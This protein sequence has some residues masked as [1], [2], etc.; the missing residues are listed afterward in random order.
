MWEQDWALLGIAPTTEPGAIKKAYALKLKATRPDDDAQAYQALRA[1]YERV[2]QWLKWQ[3]LQQQQAH[4]PDAETPAAPLPPAAVHDAP[5]MPPP[6]QLVQP[7][8]LLDGLAR[9]WQRC[10]EAAL[11]HEWT[12]VQQQLAQQP[13]S[14]QTEFSAAFA[15][16]VVDAPAL[17]DPLLKALN[18]HFG[19]L[20]DFRTERLLGTPLTHALHEALDGRLRPPALPDPVRELGAPLQ[21]LAALHEAGHAGWRLQ[22]LFFLL[23]PT[24]ARCQDLLGA[25]WL[26]RL[27][28]TPPTQRWLAG[29]TRRHLGLRVGLATLLCWGAAIAI[30]AA[31]AQGRGLAR[32]ILSGLGSS[33]AWLALSCGLLIVGLLAGSLIGV[34]L[35]LG[36]R[37]GR[38]ARRLDAWRRHRSQPWLGLAGLLFAAWLCDLQAS[39]EAAGGMPSLLP[40]WAYGRAA[41][42]FGIAGLLLA[43]PLVPMHGRVVAGLAPLVGM[44]AMDALGAWLSRGSCLLLGLAWM[45]V[46][47]AVHEERLGLPAAVPLRWLLRPMLNSFALADRWTYALALAPLAVGMAWLGLG[48]GQVGALRLFVVWVLSILA[49]GWLQSR[50]DA[51]GLSQLRA[52]RADAG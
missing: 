2:Q 34:G 25:D 28:L 41:W 27:G 14:R 44:L 50:A 45:L 30:H 13:L 7:Q 48:G 18:D 49:I 31:D 51:L 42:G 39:S 1:A 3:Q 4:Q 12:A 33:L 23:Q 20:D 29:C 16:W 46:A 52:L 21:A 35:S 32:L 38:L 40:A 9:C 11:L 37:E 17:P 6:E 26:R 43:W 8:Q 22:W 10:G 15:H 47:A 24:L 5:G 19:W 36:G